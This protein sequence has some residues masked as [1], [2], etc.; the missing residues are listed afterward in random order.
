MIGPAML[1][2]G[3]EEVVGGMRKDLE[4]FALGA[5]SH[6]ILLKVI[7]CQILPLLQPACTYI[8]GL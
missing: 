2:Q 6:P 5:Q 1:V 3:D 8:P 4:V 7:F